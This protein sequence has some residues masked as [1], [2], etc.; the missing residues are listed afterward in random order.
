MAA[1]GLDA[2]L[3]ITAS[4]S[5]SRLIGKRAYRRTLAALAPAVL[6]VFILTMMR[7]Q[8]RSAAGRKPWRPARAAPVPPTRQLPKPARRRLFLVAPQVPAPL[9]PETAAF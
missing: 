9:Q 3:T 1:I 2:V 7:R 8:P 5:T 6:S 4:K